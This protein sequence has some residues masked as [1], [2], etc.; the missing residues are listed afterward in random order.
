MSGSKRRREEEVSIPQ[1]VEKY[2]RTVF[3]VHDDP[4]IIEQST[5]RNIQP[6][7]EKDD[8]IDKYILSVCSSKQN[9]EKCVKMVQELFL[10]RL[11]TKTTRCCFVYM[12]T[13]AQCS[14]NQSDGKTFCYSHNKI[15]NTNHPY[16]KF[17]IG[18]RFVSGS[19][20][21]LLK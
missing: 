16:Y 6:L 7:F 15:V 11:S 12:T 20:K 9:T 14:E 10:L 1:K 2:S 19:N 4:M 5:A 21:K 8:E 3:R 13:M 18:R 17:K